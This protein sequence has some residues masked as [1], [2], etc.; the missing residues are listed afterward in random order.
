MSKR[1]KIALLIAVIVIGAAAAYF[2][3]TYQ[4]KEAWLRDYLY[5]VYGGEQWVKVGED[6]KYYATRVN[7]HT[8]Y[9]IYKDGVFEFDNTVVVAEHAGA[10]AYEDGV[11]KVNKTTEYC[12]QPER[13]YY[14]GDDILIT[15]D[16]TVYKYGDAISYTITNN[17][18][19]PI[20]PVSVYL[21]DIEVNFKGQWYAVHLWNAFG[22][23]SVGVFDIAP[24]DTGKYDLPIN[25][26]GFPVYGVGESGK[27]YAEPNE[28]KLRPGLYRLCKRISL[29]P[30]EPRP[31]K[32][33]YT[34]ITCTFRIK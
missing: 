14:E 13:E 15:T 24:G 5:E 3:L 29:Y 17:S 12:L 8:M 10:S 20:W 26:R 7:T 18:D 34:Y 32:T 21:Y 31:L 16:K 2:T 27:V 1:I 23:P 9:M 22:Q 19:K 30:S 4:L 6:G 33:E 25:I 11:L 28:F